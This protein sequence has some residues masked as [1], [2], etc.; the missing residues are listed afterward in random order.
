MKWCLN[1]I[2]NKHNVYLFFSQKWL[3]QPY[4]P[5]YLTFSRDVKFINFTSVAW[6]ENVNYGFSFSCACPV[7]SNCRDGVAVTIAVVFSETR[8]YQESNFLLLHVTFQESLLKSFPVINRT[9]ILYVYSFNGSLLHPPNA[10]FHQQ[11]CLVKVQDFKHSWN[12]QNLW[13]WCHPRRYR[14]EMLHGNTNNL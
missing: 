10:V 5:L 3:D 14:A 7:L 2:S 13:L 6:S 1:V 11:T 8:Y 9:F 4:L 12:R